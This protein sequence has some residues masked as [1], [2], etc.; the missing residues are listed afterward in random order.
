MRMSGQVCKGVAALAVATLV[1]ILSCCTQ[2]R[3]VLTQVNVR[4]EGRSETLFEGPI[5]TE[6][7]DV[8]ASSDTQERPCDATNNGQH[9]TPGPTPTAAAVDA[10]SIIGETFDGQ[11]Y[12]GFDDYFITRWGPDEQ[13]VAEGAYWGILVNDVFTNVGG[14]QY[15]LA[16]GDEVLWVYDAFEERP[17]LALYPAGDTSARPPLTATAK[18]DQPFE[19]QV[20]AFADNEEDNPPAEPNRHEASPYQGVEVAPVLT[21]PQGFEK[22]QTESTQTVTTNSEGKAPITF[23]E[24]GWHRIKA[25][26]VASGK[27]TAIRSNRLDVCVPAE[28]ETG[29]GELPAEDQTR[30]PPPPAG[31]AEEEHLNGGSSGTG[32]TP[33]GQASGSTPNGQA[34]STTGKAHKTSSI[35]TRR[36]TGKVELE[37]ITR[38][39][40][41][42]RLTSPGRLTVQIARQQDKR[43]DLRWHTIKTF[44]RSVR[45][46]GRVKLPLPSLPAGR[47][48]IKIT[49]AGSNTVTRRLTVTERER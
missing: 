30:T 34:S 38:R 33:N 26:V 45:T 9:T 3:A 18:L 4:I 13:D 29:C 11:W 44:A 22:V 32:G 39:R 28:G 24:P 36:Q 12:P 21:S 27:E 46:A 17:N 40:L 10:M 19:V 37:S 42:L 5:W 7:H 23:T 6:G 35:G 41:S 48:R 16:P 1:A 49:L 8:R 31:E 14:C 15:E 25:T 47:Y 2:A 20:E 43:G